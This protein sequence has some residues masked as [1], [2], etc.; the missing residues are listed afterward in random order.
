[1]PVKFTSPIPWDPKTHKKVGVHHNYPRNNNDSKSQSKENSPNSK[2]KTFSAEYNLL[3]AAQNEGFLHALSECEMMGAS[4]NERD[5][6]A[7]YP[8]DARFIMLSSRRLQSISLMDLCE[9][10]EVCVLCNNFIDDIE[11]L[12]WCPNLFCLDVHSNQ[13][14]EIF[15]ILYIS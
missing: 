5:K 14:S 4:Q 11:A 2:R 15:C 3:K 9:R 6:Q 12:K 13:V 10:L 8:G 1:M 7:S